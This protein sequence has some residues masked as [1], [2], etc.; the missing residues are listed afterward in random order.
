VERDSSSARVLKFADIASLDDESIDLPTAALLIAADEYPHLDLPEY[1]DKLERIAIDARTA[2]KG[3][4]DPSDVLLAINSV[5]FLE[6]G[7]HGNREDYYDPRNSYLNQVIDRRTGIPITLSIIYMEVAR[8]VGMPLSGVGTPR[9]FMVKHAGPTGEIYADPF[10]GG[11]LMD[12]AGCAKL[13]EDLSG[14]RLELRPE[15]LSGVG[16]KQI[17]TRILANLAGVYSAGKDYARAVRAVDR[18][19]AINPD[20]ASYYRDRGLLLLAA[21]RERESID[22]LQQYIRLSPGAPDTTS[23]RASIKKIKAELSRLN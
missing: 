14:G 17:L 12:A 13:V 16:N 1:L 3:L 8:R 21:G 15:H 19:L 20:H 4:C 18:A 22:S 10:N 23:I 11:R 7:Y 6:Y 9:H 2:S 5:V